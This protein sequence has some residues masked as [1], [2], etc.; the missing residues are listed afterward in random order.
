MNQKILNSLNEM[1]ISNSPQSNS[2]SRSTVSLCP[3]DLENDSEYESASEEPNTP[4][5]FAKISLDSLEDTQFMT[6]MKREGLS[7]GPLTFSKRESYE[8]SLIQHW[9]ETNNTSALRKYK[10]DKESHNKV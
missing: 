4:D 6:L 9:K 1:K 10:F 3:T 8:E 5:S 7:V 2:K